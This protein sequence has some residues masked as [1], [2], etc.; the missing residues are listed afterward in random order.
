MNKIIIG[1]L[2]I[3]IFLGVFYV[4]RSTNFNEAVS[5]PFEITFVEIIRSSDNKE[6]VI[7]D[8]SEV[9]N[10]MNQLSETEL[11]EKA[12]GSID[13]DESYWIIL[14][15]DNKREFGSTIYAENYML[16]YEYEWSKQNSYQIISGF[17]STNIEPFFE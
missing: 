12:M 10:L 16:I 11:T 13:F 6:V 1:I 4:K 14:Q 15:A 5:N 2:V 7:E 9:L 8:G 3:V 17:D